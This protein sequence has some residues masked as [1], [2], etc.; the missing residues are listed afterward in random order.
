MEDEYE[1]GGAQLLAAEKCR[2]CICRW[3]FQSFMP[4]SGET[5]GIL[6]PMED[7]YKKGLHDCSKQKS[8]QLVC[9]INSSPPDFRKLACWQLSL[10][11]SWRISSLHD[12]LDFAIGYG[13]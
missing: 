2:S 9:L 1:K 11:K 13:K 6:K 8:K 7:E 10:R 3:N 12:E 5:V 4:K